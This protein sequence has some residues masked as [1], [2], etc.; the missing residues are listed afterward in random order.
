MQKKLKFLLGK[1][2]SR[3]ENYV[4]KREKEYRTSRLYK[5]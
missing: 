5:F 2:Y 3:G 4:N 1:V